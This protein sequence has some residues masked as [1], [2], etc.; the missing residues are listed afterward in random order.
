VVRGEDGDGG[1]PIADSARF[2]AVDAGEKARALFDRA[3]EMVEKE[4]LLHER[5]RMGSPGFFL[6]RRLRRA[7]GLFEQGLELL[8]ESW[9]TMWLMAKTHQRL[10]EYE[11]AF[12]WMERAYQ[13]NPS[14][15]DVAREASMMAND[16]GK[17]E[18]GI[19]YA[20]R[21]TQIEPGNAGL[22]ANLALAYLLANRLGDAKREIERSLEIDPEDSISKTLQD[23]IQHFERE[24][25][26]PP[27]RTDKLAR[28]VDRN[29]PAR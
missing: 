14:Q 26:T 5:A 19:V 23:A 9:N 24:K 12:S 4:I 13:V 1:G 16:L 17:Q 22:I 2:V 28:Y 11:K 27:S 7:I 6:R 29:I 18:A 10:G 3:A 21:A 8:P 15:V 25:R 20:Y